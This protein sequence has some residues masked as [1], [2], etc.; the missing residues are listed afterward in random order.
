MPRSTNTMALPPA[1][2][3]RNDSRRRSRS[4]TRDF[5]SR[6]SSTNSL[7][8]RVASTDIHS[9][10][11]FAASA[12]RFQE[13]ANRKSMMGGAF[14][15]ADIKRWDGNRRTT[16]NWNSLKRVS[17]VEEHFNGPCSITNIRHLIPGSRVMVPERRLPCPFL[18][19]G[20]VSS[21]PLSSSFA[22]R[23]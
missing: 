13:T 20:P 21:R 4:L 3:R 19:Q 9:Q 8:Q 6:V 14:K 23:H 7:R 2:P 11:H 15:V 5:D 12:E 17:V 10:P 1:I 18:R 16:T 22:H